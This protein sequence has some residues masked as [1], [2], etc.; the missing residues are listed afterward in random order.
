[1][2]DAAVRAAAH[3]PSWDEAETVLVRDVLPYL[4]EVA[5]VRAKATLARGAFAGRSP[6]AA[7]FA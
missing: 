5:S 4:G 1:M 7:E 6:R 3:A 2:V